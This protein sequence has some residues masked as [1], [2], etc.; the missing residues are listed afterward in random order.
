MKLKTSEFTLESIFAI[1][2]SMRQVPTDQLR[3]LSIFLCMCNK[4]KF[5]TY[6]TPPSE[7]N[8]IDFGNLR[9]IRNFECSIDEPEIVYT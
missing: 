4:L 8:L 6:L 1:G 2:G 7:M 5:Q 3:Q 9:I